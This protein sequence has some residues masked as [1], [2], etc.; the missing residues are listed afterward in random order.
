MKSIKFRYNKYSPG[1]LYIMLVFGVV[2]GLLFF[3]AFLV[4][5]GIEKRAGGWTDIFQRTSQACRLF[6]IRF[7]SDC[8]GVAGMDCQKMLE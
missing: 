2:L 5:S 7:D 1:V 4:L 3:Y 8:D 6:D